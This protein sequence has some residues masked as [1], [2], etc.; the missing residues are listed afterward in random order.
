MGGNS[1]KNLAIPIIALLGAVSLVPVA[2]PQGADKIVS[3]D[4]QGGADLGTKIAAADAALGAATGRIQVHQSGSI[5]S[6]ITISSNHTLVCT[7]PVA[8]DA[9]GIDS[10]KE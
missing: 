7:N 2:M 6:T 4:Q 9:K 5:A 3:A 1:M 8:I 10:L